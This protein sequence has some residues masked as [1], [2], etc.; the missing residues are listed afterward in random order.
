MQI[1]TGEID[2]LT[3]GEAL[4]DLIS[5]EQVESLYGAQQF[6]KHQGGSPANIA[7]NLAKLDRSSAFIGKTGI[8]AF[9]AFIKAELRRAG[10]ITDHMIMDHRVHTS[11][12]FI[13]RTQGT[14]DFEAF[15]DG[16]YRLEPKELNEEA[17]RNAKVVHTSIWPVSREPSR[18]AVERAFH[19]A[20]EAGKIISFDP[21]YSSRIW[22]DHR[23]ALEVI[24]R[25][26]KLA[27]ITKP[28]LDDAHRFF[29]DK[30]AH[31]PPDAYI[32][33]YHEMGAEIVVLT[34]GK[35]G[36]LLSEGSG[37]DLQHI[38][39]QEIDVVDA[40]GAGDSFW[41]GFIAALLDEQ[42]LQRCA[43]F[44]REIVGMKLTRVGPLPDKIDRQKIYD[45]IDRYDT[46]D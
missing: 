33:R 32:P 17:V 34:M 44:A 24:P 11:V 1:P 40:T 27:T 10:V 42:P 23:E 37:S 18:A 6:E 26:L 30:E 3:M 43:L 12:I 4:I 31:L 20:H 16:D 9:G 45:K 36:I 15:R 14:P 28:S 38:P 13:S 8:G 46:N 19:I 21:N 35:E 5:V 7:V 22:P 41:A 39:A 25:M 2:L 29:G